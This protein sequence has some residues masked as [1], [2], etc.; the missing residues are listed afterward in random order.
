MAQ[1]T[2]DAVIR[3]MGQQMPSF[4]QL[5]S[6]IESLG[7]QIDQIG[8]KVRQFEKE[9]VNIYRD[10]EDRM[11]GVKGVLRDQ[12]DSMTLFSRDM[13]QLDQYARVWAS[14][15][16]FHTNDV[17]AA[18]EDAAHAGWTFDEMVQGIPQAMLLAQAGGLDL[19]DAMEYLVP[20]MKT[21]HTE[22]GD[23]GT[24][25]DQWVKSAN[26]S[27][28]TVEG[29]GETFTAL[30]ASALFGDST[31]ELFTMAAVMA[32]AGITGSTAGT[33]MRNVML[34]LVAPTKQASDAMDLLGISAEEL[35]EEDLAG[36]ED[37]IDYLN[38]LG[39]SAY[40]AEGN[41][42]PM[43]DIFKNLHAVL[44]QGEQERY[45]I[46]KKIFPM[47]S[48][49][50]AL[51]ILDAI[52]NGS[53]DEL[54]T[55]I[56]DSEG[57]AAS[58]ADTMM[59]G[60]TGSIETLLSKW[61]EFKNKV[62]ETLAPF[63]E[64]L[65]DALG[66]LVDW[67]NGL[68]EPTLTALVGGMTALAT[69]GPGLIVVGGAM[70]IFGTLGPVGLAMVGLAVGSAALA[71]ALSKLNE[72]EF[73]SH[74]GDLEL[75][76]DELGA[77]VDGLGTKFSREYGKI[78]V[79]ESAL[80]GATGKYSDLVTRLN[81]NLLTDVLTGKTLTPDEQGLLYSYA[82][83]IYNAIT[84]GIALAKGTD[85][86]FLEI[87]FGDQ[88][89]AE[90]IEAGNTA[91]Q[92]VDSYYEGLY[93]EAYSIGEELRRQF[94]LALT[95]G[96]LDENE[97]MAI[98]ATIDRYNQIEA[99]IQDRMSRE[100]FLEQLFDAQHLSAEG[101]KP[102]FEENLQKQQ[103][104]LDAVDTLYRGKWAHYRAA[105]E[106]AIANG[107]TY[108]TVDGEQRAVSEEDWAL[109]EAQL[110][111][112]WQRARQSTYDK[113][114]A[115]NAAAMQALMHDSEYMDAWNLLESLALD[116]D[117]NWSF[118]AGSWTGN[119][120]PEDMEHLVEGLEWL[121]RNQ[122]RFTQ[123][124]GEDATSQRYKTL[125]TLGQDVA[126]EIGPAIDD[127]RRGQS[128]ADGISKQ[129]DAIE[130]NYKKHETWAF[131]DYKY[132]GLGATMLH[133]RYSFE[134][135]VQP[136]QQEWIRANTPEYLYSMNQMRQ[137]INDIRENAASNPLVI[138]AELDTSAVDAYEPPT[139]TMNVVPHNYVSLDLFAEGGR[140]TQPSIFGDAGAEWAIP[141]EHS[142][143]TADLLNAARA[144]SGF[145]WGDLMSRYG[146]LGGG[147]QTMTVNY[148]PVINAGDATGVA[149]AL[150]ADKDR[151]MR[152]IRSAI[153]NQK[154]RDSVEVYA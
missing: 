53:I 26:A 37:Q 114:G 146:G 97:R 65:A 108:Y 49:S 113:Y 46:L 17:A 150:A 91:A 1:K 8:A 16:I 22:F 131:E 23:M 32:N 10:Y 106:D 102:F 2:L 104:E 127:M 129:I 134:N 119:E 69:L 135:S 92:V 142:I 74:F 24:M 4:T 77:H 83:D 78:S 87:L 47:R 137:D 68:D 71:G 153:E 121:E 21:T 120:T 50:G 115:V 15:T 126:R 6:S 54:F 94:T 63:I 76:L 154:F 18:I 144:A 88:E 116:E 25:I 103:K 38:E 90:Q 80:E 11:L 110:N 123:Y 81:E 66:S 48:I 151:L 31:Q 95:D 139:K 130:R 147:G 118:T 105:Y 133:D 99:E 89:S 5:G 33:M 138:T 96:M 67:L 140:A 75:D 132:A 93:A 9:S 61:E 55:N 13:R 109:F 59:S 45:D 27:A 86:S 136:E 60:L 70:K 98:Q 20:I 143:R 29:M 145:T 52:D 125:F 64:R 101:I 42:L 7:T 43:I 36:F 117:G 62:G 152:M 28:T 40:D 149:G 14:T 82:D 19:A 111:D 84:D 128:L 85:M 73:N 3:L 107:L 56:G 34:R 39:F 51:A 57:Y 44:P 30:S 79:F 112:E 141:E 100:A 124:L 41:L 12:Y 148:A 58:V 122:G 72:I 35:S